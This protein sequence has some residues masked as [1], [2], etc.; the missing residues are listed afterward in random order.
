MD[1]KEI[2]RVDGFIKKTEEEL[3][4]TTSWDGIRNWVFYMEVEARMKKAENTLDR[5]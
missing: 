5:R 1:W 2:Q 4:Q 3:L